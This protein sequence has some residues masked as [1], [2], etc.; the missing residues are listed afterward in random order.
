VFLPSVLVYGFV[1]YR[2]P[3]DAF[4]IMLA[5]LAVAAFADRYGPRVRS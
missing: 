5:A 2:A 3:I 4:L 1:R